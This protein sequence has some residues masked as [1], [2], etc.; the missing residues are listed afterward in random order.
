MQHPLSTCV[1]QAWH[2]IKQ[3]VNISK[4][5]RAIARPLA[6]TIK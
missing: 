2:Y 3:N 5:V 4:E 1:I 6:V